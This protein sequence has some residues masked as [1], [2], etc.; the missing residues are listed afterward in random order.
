[1]VQSMCCVHSI[2]KYKPKDIHIHTSF[3]AKQRGA[4]VRLSFLT[5]QIIHFLV[6][7]SYQTINS[8]SQEKSEFKINCMVLEGYI[9]ML[10]TLHYLGPGKVN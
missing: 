9:H 8:N 6:Q 10:C 5:N 3:Y 4:I 7:Q 2:F 1:M